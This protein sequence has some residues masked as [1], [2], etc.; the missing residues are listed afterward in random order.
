MEDLVICCKRFPFVGQ[1]FLNNLENQSLARCKETNR[2]MN[3]F[4]EN[5]R[6][7]WIRILKKNIGNFK[8]FEESWNHVIKNAPITIIQQLAHAVQEYFQIKLK[9]IL[10]VTNVSHSEMIITS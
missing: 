2:G 10:S 1:I 4:L 5:Q 9:N 3:R 6:F 7:Y 8:G